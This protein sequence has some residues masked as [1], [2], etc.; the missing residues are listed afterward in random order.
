M[1]WL[2]I[3]SGTVANRIVWSGGPEWTP[4]EGATVLEDRDQ[5]NIGD[6]YDA[7]TD[8]FQPSENS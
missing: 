1:I 8:T 5:V 2:V 4:P 7:G 3:L 6:T